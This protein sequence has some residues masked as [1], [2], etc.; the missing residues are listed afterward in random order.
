MTSKQ[1]DPTLPDT[2]TTGDRLVG[3]IYRRI[4]YGLAYEEEAS[5]EDSE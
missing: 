1:Q 4:K 5:S 2:R 3:K